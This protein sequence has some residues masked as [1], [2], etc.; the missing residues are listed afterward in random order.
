MAASAVFILDYR[1]KILIS[2]NYRGDVPMGV[3]S[4]FIGKILEEE[5]MNVKPVT[6][7]DGVTYAF[8]KHNNLF[9]ILILLYTFNCGVMVLDF[10][11]IGNNR[12][13]WKCS[14]NTPIPLQNSTS[15]S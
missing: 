15:M 8:I 6:E 3:A 7:E 13:K 14:S 12:S 5:E 11:S 4:R 2:R 9:C 1:G 10:L